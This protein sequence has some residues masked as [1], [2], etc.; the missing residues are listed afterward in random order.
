MPLGKNFV[1]LENF[2]IDWSAAQKSAKELTLSGE[3]SSGK[4]A[5]GDEALL[6]HIAA[7]HHVDVH[8]FDLAGSGETEL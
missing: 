4:P 6:L 3:C 2:S 7:L 8:N 1:W 5:A